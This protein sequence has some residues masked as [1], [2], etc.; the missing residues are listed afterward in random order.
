MPYHQSHTP[1]NLYATP[2]LVKQAVKTAVPR[3]DPIEIV[4]R[5]GRVITLP[6][7][8]APATRSSKRKSQVETVNALDSS[9]PEVPAQIQPTILAT[10]EPTVQ[11]VSKQ[12]SNKKLPQKKQEQALQATTIEKISVESQESWNSEDDPNRYLVKPITEIFK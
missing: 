11:Q 6:P 12:Y 8:E 4:R 5:D 3:K 2:P 10:P 1:S 9:A 7:I